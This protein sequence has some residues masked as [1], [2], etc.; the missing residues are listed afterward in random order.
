[1]KKVISKF[2]VCIVVFVLTLFVSSSIYNKGN[3][4][5]TTTM[6]EA[7]LPMVHITTN[8]IAYNYLYGLRQEMDGSFFRDTITPLGDGR[9]LGF[10]VDKY[11][12]DISEISFE[13]R[14]IDGTRLVERTKV[15]DYNDTGDRIQA[16]ITIKDLIESGTEYNWILMLKIK[17]DIVRYYTRIIDSEGYHTYEKLSFVRDFHDKTFNQEQAKD[18]VTYLES[19]SKGDNTTLSH[20][21]IHCS[22]KQITW[23]DL[24]I[25]Q[26]SEPHIIISEIESQTASI[27]MNYRVQT[28]EGKKKDKYNVVE[29]FRIRYTPD[30]TY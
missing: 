10:V 20:V 4:E 13:V 23:A 26:I 15:S 16:T 21:D 22:L 11:D 6:S 8:G 24:N 14:S 27:R 19:N 18:L 17:N 3:K 29:F 25:K 1:M 7:S 2:A 30:R 12:N 28:I 5:L 9:T